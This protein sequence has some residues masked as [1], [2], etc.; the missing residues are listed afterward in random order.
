MLG[1]QERMGQQESKLVK[2]SVNARGCQ[3]GL[4]EKGGLVQ[5]PT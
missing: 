2:S 1:R 3:W 4:T 5:V